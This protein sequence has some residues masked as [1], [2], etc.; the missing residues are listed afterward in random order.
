MDAVTNLEKLYA[1]HGDEPAAYS[2]EVPDRDAVEFGLE[3]LA[4]LWK[5]EGRD[6]DDFALSRAIAVAT[7]IGRNDPSKILRARGYA[8]VAT[9]WRSRR[10]APFHFEAHPVDEEGFK[11]TCGPLEAI[12][13]ASPEQRAVLVLGFSPVL[14]ASAKALGELRPDNYAVARRALVL[15][16]LAGEAIEPGDAA[17]GAKQALHVA[18]R[19]LWGQVAFLAA[20]PDIVPNVEKGRGAADD[21]DEPRACAGDLLLAVDAPSATVEL[22]KVWSRLSRDPLVKIALLKGL[23]DSGLAAEGVHPSLRGPLLH[24]LDPD[25][26]NAAVRYWSKRTLTKLLQLDPDKTP[27]GEL[28]AKWLALGDWDIG[29]RRS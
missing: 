15:A 24:D 21:A 14:E 8:T 25:E 2:T 7:E 3:N 20:M 27:D 18:V 4:V 10:N 23:G 9:I 22:A 16:A 26:E 13:A 29:A 19:A 17:P 11:T 5:C 1:S 12:V 6:L 28:R